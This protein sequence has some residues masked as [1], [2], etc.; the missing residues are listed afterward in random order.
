MTNNRTFPVAYT[1]VNWLS[2]SFLEIEADK[3]LTILEGPNGVGK[4]SIMMA[5]YI[6]LMPD[7]STFR[8]RDQQGS[9]TG[10][11]EIVGRINKHGPVYCAMTLVSS[12]NE[13]TIIGLHLAPRGEAK[14]DISPFVINKV[15]AAVTAG[16][17]FITHGK[18]GGIVR[19]LSEVAAA[20]EMAGAEFKKHKVGDYLK[21]L[22][23]LGVHAIDMASDKDRKNYG[24]AALSCMYGG[25]SKDFQSRLRDFLL[26]EK[27]TVAQQLAG[28]T[29]S[30]RACRR[31]RIQTREL[32]ESSANVQSIVE[33]SREMLRFG[34]AGTFQEAGRLV[35]LTCRTHY[36]YIVA[37]KELKA[38]EEVLAKLQLDEA[39]A[40]R[41]KG[42][43]EQAWAKARTD[44]V[45]AKEAFGLGK[46]LADCE[47]KLVAA[48]NKQKQAELSYLEAKA[49][50]EQ[51]AA[52]LHEKRKESTALSLQIAS[53][54]EEY[55][56]IQMRAAR[57]R[58]AV[59][60]QTEFLSL[61]GKRVADVEAIAE[62]I[63]HEDKTVTD[64]RS[65]L[66]HIAAVAGRNDEVRSAW[67][68]A[69]SAALTVLH[70]EQPPK[71]L[72]EKIEILQ[73]LYERRRHISDQQTS[74]DEELSTLVTQQDQLTELKKKLIS[75]GEADIDSVAA[76]EKR[77][78][79]LSGTVKDL[80]AL[81]TDK[82]K[83]KAGLADS[84]K[85][86]AELAILRE[87]LKAWHKVHQE[88][89]A[90]ILLVNNPDTP[91]AKSAD[92][93]RLS[94][95]TTAEETTLRATVASLDTEATAVHM[96][97]S[98]I[99]TSNDSQEVIDS[100][101]KVDGI[102]ASSLFEE[103][104][105][106]EAPRLQAWLGT[107]AGSIV[108][109]DPVVAAESFTEPPVNDIYLV[110]REALE[111]CANRLPQGESNLVKATDTAGSIRIS[112]LP[113]AP[114]LGRQ[115]RV[116]EQ[117]RLQL[118]LDTIDSDIAA[119]RIRERHLSEV[120]EKTRILMN[121]AA[122]ID[123][124]TP[125]TKV[126]AKSEEIA[127]N[128][129]KKRSLDADLAKATHD[130]AGFEDNLGELASLATKAYLLDIEFLPERIS[131]LKVRKAKCAR[132]KKWSDNAGKSLVVITP[133]VRQLLRNPPLSDEDERGLEGSRLCLLEKE[134]T[135]ILAKTALERL[136]PS[137]ESLADSISLEEEAR[138]DSNSKRLTE[139]LNETCRIISEK[140][141][142]A[143]LS[144]A[145]IYRQQEGSLNIANTEQQSSQTA[146]N[147]LAAE[148]AEHAVGTATEAEVNSK[149][150]EEEKTDIAFGTAN[151]ELTNAVGAIAACKAELEHTRSASEMAQ[152]SL[153]A[154]RQVSGTYRN[155]TLRSLRKTLSA[156][157]D[158]TRFLKDLPAEAPGETRASIDPMA[159]CSH[160]SELAAGLLLLAKE[161]AINERSPIDSVTNE[162][163]ERLKSN[164]NSVIKGES[165]AIGFR[166]VS[167]WATTL[168]PEEMVASNDPDADIEAMNMR[169]TSLQTRLKT[170]EAQFVG[171]LRHTASQIRGSIN[172]ERRRING[173]N[174]KL[175]KLA[176]GN[177]SGA[178]VNPETITT[179]E[180]FLVTLQNQP[181]LFSDR[182]MTY[183]TI[184]EFLVAIYKE[185]TRGSLSIEQILDYRTYLNLHVQNRKVTDM[186]WLP[187]N[188]STGEAIAVGTAIYIMV[189]DNWEHRAAV[190]RKTAKS[191]RLLMLDETG[192]LSADTLQ[193][194]VNMCMD[195]EVTLIIAA[196]S[197]PPGIFGTAYRMAIDINGG[198]KSF[199]VFRS[200]TLSGRRHL[201]LD[202]NNS[203]EVIS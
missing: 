77:H 104:S 173:F 36:E 64:C 10:I 144:A 102:L 34:V 167:G 179:M 154:A 139:L 153:R 56:A 78:A 163:L 200:A 59:A 171:H 112:P 20:A 68:K 48:G 174:T 76:F 197:T 119:L 189:F 15:P 13:R 199:R 147:E 145:E 138:C 100:A 72:L 75:A 38:R 89:A 156:M 172:Q 7:Q 129:E 88:L 27:P 81:I 143:E 155:V 39:E 90:L 191:M 152:I 149:K 177:V 166:L 175:E 85:L 188:A 157:Y 130:L 193:A 97:I 161:P 52:V 131:C 158:R 71:L 184:E 120:A 49:K 58:S 148:I 194:L 11:S 95:A 183:D 43:A 50:H 6:L 182:N 137:I 3:L 30:L 24:E 201:P 29:E 4:S 23:A 69:H 135:A 132:Y 108:V 83:E 74:I 113:E 117:E 80:S 33:K 86:E 126:S 73:G 37:K 124:G 140:I 53:C 31:G 66:A 196:P 168:Y 105:L 114:L 79:E 91:L 44:Y 146:K 127:A 115:A 92:I 141:E 164:S 2:A 128:N 106:E 45:L 133:D 186:T 96:A 192:R 162:L 160:A 42:D 99:A 22:C 110:S 51:I 61:R 47:V 26:P 185:I 55:K 159:F 65:E 203:I 136:K 12:T 101:R 109:A 134:E 103:V 151:T 150:S 21:E 169:L 60:A 125:Q 17:L 9:Q 123:A 198:E 107:L 54:D 87:D 70:K 121:S 202:G 40:Q 5:V 25:M 111:E 190:A 57:H 180:R 8:F 195:L 181:D 82:E 46:R 32:Q 142:P 98:A 1:L 93:H 94:T 19:E 14:I 28:I 62:G 187:V 118:K 16:G 67:E 35:K 178:R 176:F 122:L 18:E 84:K 116:K 165:W 63:L 41:K 170:S